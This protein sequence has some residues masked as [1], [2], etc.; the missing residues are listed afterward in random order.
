MA[1]Q[2][3]FPGGIELYELTL[4]SYVAK[5]GRRYKRGEQNTLDTHGTRGL[6]PTQFVVGKTVVHGVEELGNDQANA[7][8]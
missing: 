6:I 1:E 3:A 4:Q 2:V 5:L 7:S 8:A